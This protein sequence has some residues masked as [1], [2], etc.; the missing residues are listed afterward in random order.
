MNDAVRRRLVG[1]WRL[2][3]YETVDEAGRRNRPYGD[4]VGRLTYDADGNMTGQVMRPNRT[5]VSLGEGYAQQLRGAYI[6]Y[7]AYFGT[8][9]VASN[10]ESI[11]HRVDGSLNPAWVGGNQVRSMRFEGDR[12]ILHANVE[13]GGGIVRH[14]LT[15]ERC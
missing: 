11:V 13:K 6:G 14:E 10:G 5:P 8:Y 7:I 15:W 4:A 1:T 12:L 3:L 9:D 2:V